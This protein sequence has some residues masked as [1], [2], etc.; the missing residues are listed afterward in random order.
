MGTVAAVDAGE[1]TRFAHRTH[2]LYLGVACL[3]VIEFTVSATFIASYF[4]LMFNAPEWPPAGLEPPELVWSSVNLALL[5]TSSGTMWWAGQ[6]INR[7]STR[8]LTLG[9]GLSVLLATIVLVLRWMQMASFEFRWDSHPYGSIV[10]TIT[11]FHFVHVLSAAVGTAVVTL[12][13]WRGYFTPE[14]QLGVVV[15]TLYWYF[16]SG[17]WVAFYLTLYWAPRLMSGGAQ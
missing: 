15:D 5:L 6:G 7:G 4:Y 11:G 17:I 16:V 1:L 12:L 10:W 2:P 9:M 14:R 8:I 13:A 3:V